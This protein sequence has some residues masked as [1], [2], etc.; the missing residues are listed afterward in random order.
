MIPEYRQPDLPVADE[1]PVQADGQVADG[2]RAGVLAPDIAWKSYFESEPLRTLI[3]RALDHNRDLRV[4]LLRIDQAR[5]LYRIQRADTLPVVSG[6]T[7]L[8]RQGVPEDTSA[9]GQSYNSSTLSANVGVTAYELDFFGRVK[10]L[11]QE[12]LAT[13][14]ATEEAALNTRIALIAETTDAFLN[15]LANKKLLSL[16]K[17][18]CRAYQETYAVI[19][20]RYEVGSAAELDLSQAAT[21]VESAKVS[22]ALYTRLAAQAKNAVT[23]LAGTGVTDILDSGET[24]DR[25]RFMDALPVGLPSK[26]LLQRP[27]IRQAELLLKAANADIGA[28]RAALYPTI[29]LTGAFGL[30]S[31]DLSSLF[32]SGAAYAWNFTPS[33]AIPIFNRAGIRASLEAAEVSERIAAA[34]YETVVQTAFKE[35][36]DQLAARKTYADQMRAQNALVAQTRKTYI[37]SQARY[38][39]GLDDFLA[40]LDSQRSLFAA[41]QSAITVRQA[42]LSNQVNLYKVL[43]G[44]QI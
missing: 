44:G 27:D 20:G 26:V 5:A 4:A 3:S 9:T 38:E 13:Y 22:I 2:T 34:E 35:V 8:A 1:W 12:A 43:G 28:A 14:L 24:I 23:L 39:N 30:A 16:A 29:S 41:E 6:G 36:A 37:L 32:S 40:V 17:D 18:T 15:Y 11:N 10:S 33:L 7:A 42:Y 21:S 31:D 19:K 25:I